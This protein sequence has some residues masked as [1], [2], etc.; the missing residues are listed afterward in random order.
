MPLQTVLRIQQK[1]RVSAAHD[2]NRTSFGD[3][4]PSLFISFWITDF[5][6]LFPSRRSL[7]PINGYARVPFPH[8]VLLTLL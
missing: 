7:D 8:P 6:D 2:E 3:K 1:Y 4:L 5:V